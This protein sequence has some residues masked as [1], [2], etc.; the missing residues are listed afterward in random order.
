MEIARKQKKKI[1][2]ENSIHTIAVESRNG[3]HHLEMNIQEA[4]YEENNPVKK[5]F[6]LN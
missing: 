6:K 1:P 5:L 3:I 4:L 2:E